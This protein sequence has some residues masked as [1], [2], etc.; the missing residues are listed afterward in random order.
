MTSLSTMHLATLACGID[1]LIDNGKT[2]NLRFLVQALLT[3]RKN[4]HAF[5]H[6]ESGYKFLS[7]LIRLAESTS[8]SSIGKDKEAI[9]L[10]ATEFSKEA[11]RSMKMTLK[12]VSLPVRNNKNLKEQNQSIYDFLWIVLDLINH[13]LTKRKSRKL[14][15]CCVDLVKYIAR[16][17]IN[18]PYLLLEHIAR[19]MLSQNLSMEELIEKDGDY[20]QKKLEWFHQ[21]SE[22]QTSYWNARKGIVKKDEV[23][24]AEKADD[25][26]ECL[27]AAECEIEDWE[28][29][30]GALEVVGQ[31]KLSCD[32]EPDGDWEDLLKMNPNFGELSN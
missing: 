13:D 28:Q 16:H 30:E 26:K 19:D 6:N 1:Q 21:K 4:L 27:G 8:N 11:T 3:D 12:S 25:Q 32:V 17:G 15:D 10:I 20:L 2:K 5:L 18:P 29:R 9:Y 23:D 7:S 22:K 31:E 14:F 24:K